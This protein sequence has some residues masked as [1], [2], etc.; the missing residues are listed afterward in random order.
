MKDVFLI[1]LLLTA[2]CQLSVVF[3]SFF[4]W[5]GIAQQM[6]SRQRGESHNWLG[7]AIRQGRNIAWSSDCRS[8]V[9]IL[10]TTY[11]SEY[12]GCNV[13]MLGTVETVANGN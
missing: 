11:L 6:V 7:T 9:S 12:L 10:P 5:R 2:A 13:R 1:R 8:T 4:L 3:L